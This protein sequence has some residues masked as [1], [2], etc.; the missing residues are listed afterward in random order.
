[1]IGKKDT[2]EKSPKQNFASKS[3]FS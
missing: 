2:L 3:A 1:M